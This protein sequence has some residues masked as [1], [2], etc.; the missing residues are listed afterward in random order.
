M[1]A[2]LLK[3]NFL[4]LFQEVDISCNLWFSFEKGCAA[5]AK[6]KPVKTE[7]AVYGWPITC[8]LLRLKPGASIYWTLAFRFNPLSPNSHQNLLLTATSTYQR[9][10]RWDFG[11]GISYNNRS[12]I[13]TKHTHRLFNKLSS[14]IRW[15]ST[16]GITHLYSFSSLFPH[17]T[18]L[19]LPNRAWGDKWNEG[20]HVP[21][22]F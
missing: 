11:T 5:E 9:A 16:C 22:T 7:W 1:L 17:L 20:W 10:H 2:L 14:G 19:S 13:V 8:L 4:F 15:S 3:C 21:W 6:R 18:S 12:P